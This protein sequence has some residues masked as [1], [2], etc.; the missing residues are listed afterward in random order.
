M[1]FEARTRTRSCPRHRVSVMS[2]Q[3][4]AAIAPSSRPRRAA[5]LTP[6]GALAVSALDAWLASALLAALLL[7]PLFLWLRRDVHARRRAL[8]GRLDELAN[9]VNERFDELSRRF[10][11]VDREL[12]ALRERTAG[13]EGALE[14]SA[15]ADAAPDDDPAP[16][17]EAELTQQQRKRRRPR[18]DPA[19]QP[20]ETDVPLASP[21]AVPSCRR[22][23]CA[24]TSPT[25][26]IGREATGRPASSRRP[27]GTPG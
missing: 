8:D 12:T 22:R 2:C 26:R 18:R 10:D 9:G 3:R 23:R 20:E 24:R 15:P 14:A 1:V 27:S 5:T 19:D 25:W 4:S 16:G 7:W 17:R 11:Q 21:T 6:A 13:L